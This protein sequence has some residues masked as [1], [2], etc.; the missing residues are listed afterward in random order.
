MPGDWIQSDNQKENNMEQ[1]KLT[2]VDEIE[3]MADGVPVLAVEG[4][5]KLAMDVKTG[6]SAQGHAW[7]KQF[8]VLTNGTAEIAC[9]L[10][11]ALDNELSKDEKIRIENTQ[12]KKGVWSGMVKGSYQKNGERK[13]TLEI[14]ANQVKITSDNANKLNSEYLEPLGTRK[15]EPDPDWPEAE[16][17]SELVKPLPIISRDD[18]WRRKEQRDIEVQR[19]IIRQHSQSMALEVLKLKVGLNELT[20]EDLTPS[21]LKTL[22]DYFDSDVLGATQ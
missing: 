5:V 9:S 21:K 10:W 15:L 8:F 6:T 7:S 18:Y 20:V 2:P 11:D 17:Q 22:A 19:F 13:H 4:T 3:D 14:R 1:L 16:K 12:N